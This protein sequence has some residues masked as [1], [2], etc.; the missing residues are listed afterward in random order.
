MLDGTLTGTGDQTV[1]STDAGAARGPILDL[2]R[3][4][5]SPAAS[6]FIGT[7]RFSGEDSAGNKETYA[8]V[9]PIIDDATSGSEDSHLSFYT[10]QAGT[11]TNRASIGGGLY[12][13]GTTDPGAGKINAT[14]VQ[15]NGTPLVARV[16]QVVNT[17]TGAVAT[18]ST[19]IPFD[20]TIPQNTEG[21]EYMTLAVTPG[22]VNNKL[23]IDVVFTCAVSALASV[24][25]ALFQDSN[26]N[27]IAV[28]TPARVEAAGVMV[29]AAFTHYMTAGT[30]SATTFKVRAGP[31][32]GTLTFNGSGGA[33]RFGGVMA[34]S[35]TITEIVV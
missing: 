23:R 11:T 17:Q 14:E 3:D 34:S 10:A 20:D 9:V 1:T 22:N 30:V 31:S 8:E 6:D 32:A 18:G 7:L 35:I 19:T 16:R 2:Y 5:A 33:R 28:S 21:D 26:A 27:A 25:V 13:T 24:A 12:M 29:T 4:S 15:V